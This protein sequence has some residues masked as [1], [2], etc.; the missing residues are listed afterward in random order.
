MYH[1]TIPSTL[2]STLDRL[3]FRDVVKTLA[4][5][6]FVILLVLFANYLVRFLG[7]VAIGLLPQ[8]ILFL[9]V[10]LEL[11]KIL[12]MLIPPAFFFAILWVLGRMYRDSEMAAL[13]ASGIGLGRIYRAV[14]LTALPLALLVSWMMLSVL[15][16]AKTQAVNI[17]LAQ[18]Q[19][20]EITGI[21]PG[22][23]NE[24]RN[25][26]LLI[27]AEQIDKRTGK[28]E[29]LFIQHLQGGEPTIILARQAYQTTDPASGERLIVLDGGRHYQMAGD[30]GD[31]SVGSFEAYQFRVPEPGVLV[32]ERKSSSKDW[33]ELL[34]SDD[35][36]DQIE[37]QTRLSYPLAVLAFAIIAVPL[38]QSRPRQGLYGRMGM[39]IFVY[40]IFMNLMQVAQN[41]MKRDVIPLWLGAWWV[42]LLM[43]LT[44]GLLILLDSLWFR[45]WRRRHWRLWRRRPA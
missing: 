13:A 33:R 23:F 5:I 40:F 21:K 37:L 12:G 35:Q 43:A 32:T 39:A 14:L 20:T 26:S 19:A 8:E 28:L 42:P 1:R 30:D 11:V 22:V 34:A 3:L 41:L 15:P 18:R 45:G 16:W 29:N 25:G 4:V 9:I 31:Y 38:A 36:R 17:K 44:A 7:K 6:L 24:F 2:F 27:F 10:G